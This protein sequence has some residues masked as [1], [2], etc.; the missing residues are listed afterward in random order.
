MVKVFLKGLQKKWLGGILAPLSVAIFV[1]IVAGIWP[2]FQ[3]QIESFQEIFQ[4]P[5]YKVFL[6]ELGLGDLSTWFGFNSV[7]IFTWLEMLMVFLTIFIPARIITAEV[8]K[9]TFDIVLSYPI[10]RWRYLLEKFGVYLF[11][12]LL[13]PIIL[14][15]FTYI[16]TIALGETMNYA[17]FTYIMI[18]FWFQFFA[19]GAITLL[20]SA[21]FLESKKTIAVAGVLNIGQWILVRIGGI[22]ESL[23]FLKYFSIFNYMG[24]SSI[25]QSGAFP[26]GEFFVLL[27]IGIAALTASLIIFDKREIK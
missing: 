15:L 10:P 23:N 24:G 20:C 14:L 26:I 1:P 7:Y 21:I 2:S 3:E 11:Y 27:G 18:G 17:V 22:M 4:N 12:N 5:V 19:L 8:E 9:R 16:C 25:I 13:Y 6:G